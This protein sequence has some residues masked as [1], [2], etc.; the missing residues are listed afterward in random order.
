MY[1]L[2]TN[3]SRNFG[4]GEPLGQQLCIGCEAFGDPAMRRVVGV[5]NDTKQ[6]SLSEAS[7]ATVFI[8]LTQAPD[9]T[10]GN[11]RQSSTE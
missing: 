6:R 1:P 5:V 7:P 2:S 10:K 3:V 11:L 8:P 4:S 9:G